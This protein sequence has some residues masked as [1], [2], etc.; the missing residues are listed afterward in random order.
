MLDPLAPAWLDY[1][2]III[3]IIIIS[4]IIIMWWRHAGSVVTSR[5]FRLFLVL[6]LKNP[7]KKID[8]TRETHGTNISIAYIASE[9]PT[10]WLWT[11][12]INIYGVVVSSRRYNTEIAIY[13]IHTRPGGGPGDW[14]MIGL[15]LLPDYEDN[16]VII[17]ISDYCNNPIII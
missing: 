12:V 17:I 4:L 9:L 13:P 1:D 15:W 6:A 16:Q 3:R 2:W 5:V 7:L 8:T 14:I 10:S 11:P